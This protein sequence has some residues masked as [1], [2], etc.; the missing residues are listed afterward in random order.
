MEIR[1]LQFKDDLWDSVIQYAK[2]CLWKAGPYLSTLMLENGFT[3]WERVF[4]ASEGVNIAGYCTIVKKDCIPDV[5]YTPYIS[6][7]FVGEEFRGQRLSEQMIKFVLTYAKH[8][9]FKEVFLVSG[10]KGLYEKYGFTKI[11]DKKDFWGNEEQ[12]FHINIK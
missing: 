9:G 7:V 2:N 1:T 5:S 11:D 6:H 8:I 10:E 4:V 3:E 12:I